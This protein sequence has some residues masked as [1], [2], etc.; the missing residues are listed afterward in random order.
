VNQRHRFQPGPSR[1][2]SELSR[3]LPPAMTVAASLTGRALPSGGVSRCSPR[4]AGRTVARQMGRLARP[5]GPPA[6][7]DR[8]VRAGQRRN[9]P[10]GQ[11][12]D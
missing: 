12:R 8:A 3:R 10:A 2:V 5:A 11:N 9:I 7:P 4:Q 6:D 1:P